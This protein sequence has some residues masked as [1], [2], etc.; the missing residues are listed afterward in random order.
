MDVNIKTILFS[1]IIFI[2]LDALFIY[3]N[4]NNFLNMLSNI[5]NQKVTMDIPSVIITYCFLYFGLY[6]FIIKPKREPIDAF[7]LGIV[8]YGTYEFTNRSIF[9]NWTLN[10]ALLDT[11]W[12]GILYGTTTYLTYKI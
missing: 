12:G 3:I 10:T 7:L 4:R 2:F 6:Y 8:I 11:L 9:K 1:S 5:Q